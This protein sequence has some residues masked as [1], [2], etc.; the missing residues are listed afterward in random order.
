MSIYHVAQSTGNDH[1]DGSASQPFATINHAAQLALPG[2]TV[3]VHAG[4]YREAVQPRFG[5]KHPTSAITYQAAAGEKVVIKGSEQI[6]QWE[7][8]KD[9]ANG[10]CVYKTV[11]PNSFFGNFNPYATKLFGDWL[12]EPD[13]C[14][15]HLGDVYLDG[16]SLYE[17][18]QLSDLDDPQVRTHGPCSPWCVEPQEAI[19]HPEDTV[20]QWYAVV[21]DT[22]TTIYANFGAID[23]KDHCIEINVREFCF[24]PS[25]MH[26]NF[27]T[28]D[29]F[30]MCHAACQWAP[31]TGVQ[32]GMI[33]TY[34]SKGW[35]I[36]NCHL[37]DAK[38]SAI[39]MGKEI[40][41]GD[42][43]HMRFKRK[44]GYQMQLEAVFKACER[45]WSKELIGS[46]EVAFN[47]IHDCG[48]NGVVGHLGC[49]NSH[50]HHNHIYNIAMKHEYFGHEIAGIK[51]HAAI[52][53]VIDH[54]EF[55]DSTL[56]IW[57]DWQAQGTRV[58]KNAFYDNYRDLMIEVTHG[59]CLVDNNIFGSAYN[60]D[61]VAQGT[62]L[63]NNLFA[64]TTRTIQVLNRAT[65][66]HLPHSTKVAGYACVYSGDD[67]VYGN[68]FIGGVKFKDPIHQCGTAFYDGHCASWD[69]YHALTKATGANDLEGFELIKEAVYI[70]HNAYLKGAPSF[71]KEESK[72]SSDADPQFKIYRDGTGLQVELTLP[73][74]VTGHT[75]A[76]LD[77]ASLGA[78]R[79]TEGYYENGDGTPL[80]LDTD[81][82]GESY[83][84]NAR[85]IGPLHFV[86]G[87]NKLKLWD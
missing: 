64:G 14:E 35:R 66:Y 40:T 15:L 27:I 26:T 20:K 76:A 87:H 18:N 16:K 61:N 62:A 39:S 67:R 48:Q 6:T 47:T 5:G 59:P 10:A 50:I 9:A 74:E 12:M 79:L 13:P 22:S 70:N 8:Y 23:P 19:P 7:K 28:I 42:C 53:V 57:L 63:V 56:G 45:G 25:Q 2:D 77:T 1:H 75:F 65:P 52:D 34:W 73:K 60:F 43:E 85:Q 58:S 46:H 4:V 38:N 71:A 21:D 82:L 17:A 44:P 36:L 32:R 84:T 72:I 24:A 83:P 51:L 11:L 68:I 31:P 30:E 86:E 69:E 54:N 78:T 55:H 37:H 29:G 41:T 49:I 3:V 81:L 33:D 80:T